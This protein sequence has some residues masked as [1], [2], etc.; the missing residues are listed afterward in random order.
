MSNIVRNLKVTVK[1]A[2]GRRVSSTRWL[3]R[4][5]NDPYVQL[6]KLEGYRSR[7]AYKLLEIHEKYKLFSKG[8]RV[9][10]LGAAPGGWSQVAA[11][12]TS[13]EK[14][15]GG[16][17]LAIDL[18]SMEYILGVTSMQCD[19]LSL[20]SEDIAQWLDKK[21]VDVVLSDMAAASS[22]HTQTDHI[23]IM[24]LCADALLFAKEHFNE[25]GSFVAKILRGGTENELLLD[26]KTSFKQVKHFKPK[27]SRAD[28]A[29]MY[30]VCLGYRKGD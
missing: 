29:E 3:Q 11:Q 21:K 7:A 20:K 24:M 2:K 4:Q 14:I 17:V 30:V 8:Q 10:D 18:L 22:G 26:L 23:R 25:G 1:T 6:A 27:S 9:V 28:S 16:K 5:L 12:K 15:W 13:A 19:F